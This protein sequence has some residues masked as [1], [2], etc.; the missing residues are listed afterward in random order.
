M[1]IRFCDRSS[2]TNKIYTKL[3]FL[4]VTNNVVI[5]NE[6]YEKCIV[7]VLMG[8]L[9]SYNALKTAEKSDKPNDIRLSF[10]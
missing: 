9:K 10:L 6:S 5:R 2:H 7:T 1:N 3:M 8:K 4:H